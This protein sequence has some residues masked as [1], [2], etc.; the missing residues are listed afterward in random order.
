MPLVINSLGGTHT[1]THTHARTHTYMHTNVED[2]SNFKKPFVCWL[3]VSVPG[4]TITSYISES[5]LSGIVY[6]LEIY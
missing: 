6:W 5:L 2:K 4:L 1:H 3:Q